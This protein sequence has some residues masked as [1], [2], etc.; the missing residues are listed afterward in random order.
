ME[1]VSSVLVVVLVGLHCAMGGVTWLSDWLCRFGMPDTAV[2]ASALIVPSSGL[3]A[4]GAQ[5]W[6]LWLRM[7]TAAA[8]ESNETRVKRMG[9]VPLRAG[10]KWGGSSGG[11]RLG[12]FGRHAST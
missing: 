12:M 11:A 10:N 9:D 1:G 7:C 8:T 6:V 4:Q 3:D 2:L 5:R